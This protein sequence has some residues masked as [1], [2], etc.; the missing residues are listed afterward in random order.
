ME[1]AKSH[2]AITKGWVEWVRDFW[3]GL[4]HF[5]LSTCPNKRTLMARVGAVGTTRTFR[6][7]GKVP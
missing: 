3:F 6:V 5:A 7:L 4:L 2:S 1:K